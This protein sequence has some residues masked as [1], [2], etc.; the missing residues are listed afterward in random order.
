MC[1][2]ISITA[3]LINAD[4]CP[5]E[6]EVPNPIV[7]VLNLWSLVILLLIATLTG[8]CFS[9]NWSAPKQSG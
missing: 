6:E 8:F 5:Y 9:P 7:V 2:C 4:V 3:M 1:Y